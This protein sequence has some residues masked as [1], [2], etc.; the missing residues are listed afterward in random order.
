MVGMMLH[1]DASTHAWLPGEAGKHDLVVTMDDATSAIYSAFLVDQE[2]T[3]SSLRGVRDVVAKHG[4]FCSLYT[5]RGSHYFETPVA[6][7]QNIHAAVGMRFQ[8]LVDHH[9]AARVEYAILFGENDA[10]FGFI[11][12]GLPDHLLVAVLE[13]VQR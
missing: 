4:L 9:R 5:G 2:G 1:Q 13:D 11:A 7:R 12:D 10:E 3:A 6:A 8:D